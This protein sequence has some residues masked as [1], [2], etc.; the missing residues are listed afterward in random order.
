MKYLLVALVTVCLVAAGTAAPM[1]SKT[2]TTTSTTAA[3]EGCLFKG[4]E[5]KAGETYQADCNTCHCVGNNL[6]MCTLMLCGP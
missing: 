1:D 6:A 4:I 3:P 5:Y 2:T